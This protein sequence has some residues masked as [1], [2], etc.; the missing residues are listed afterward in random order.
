MEF[1]KKTKRELK[2]LL[3]YKYAWVIILIIIIVRLI[4]R[5]KF[6]STEGFNTGMGPVFIYYID[7]GQADSTLITSEFGNILIDGGENE[8]ENEL[9]SFIK[10]KGVTT[11]DYVVATHPHTDHIG[12]LDKIIN[13]LDVKNILMTNGLSDTTTY[14]KFL[15]S[16]KNKKIMPTLAKANSFFQLGELEFTIL[17]PVNNNYENLN[18]YS[19]SLK[20][21]YKG[22]SFLFTGDAE[23]EAENEILG[24]NQNISAD[25]Y[26]AGHHGSSTSTSDN[27]LEAVNPHAVIISCG[28]N[29]P[30]G[31]P[32]KETIEKLNGTQ[33]YRTDLLGTIKLETDGYRVIINDEPL[34]L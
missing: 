21:N 10:S 23:T 31:H 32:H 12:G 13:S 27:F 30:Y 29:N 24:L 7:V 16:I 8:T 11:L 28:A 2:K 34:K 4:P 1:N 33:V 6:N 20:M 18:N 14:E 25:V 3:K 26:K 15:T 19:I 9:L 5:F 17:N 22:R